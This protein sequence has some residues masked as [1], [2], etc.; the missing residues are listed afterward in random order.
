DR[1]DLRRDAGGRIELRCGNR[2][3]GRAR[4]RMAAD[5]GRR[6][7]PPRW[8]DRESRPALRPAGA[9]RG[10]RGGR[11][12]VER[13]APR[14]Q[15]ILPDARVPA[16]RAAAD[17]SGARR[18]TGSRLAGP[19]AGHPGRPA[20][21][22]DTARS[23]GA[24]RPRAVE[25]GGIRAGG[26][27]R[28]P[29]R[30]EG[31]LGGR[32]LFLEGDPPAGLGPWLWLAAAIPVICAEL[33]P[34]DRRRLKEI[35]GWSGPLHIAAGPDGSFERDGDTLPVWRVPV[36]SA[37]ERAKL[38][39]I[40]TG[41]AELGE[42]LGPAHRH[43]CARIAE[44]ARAGRYHAEISG[45]T[46]IGPDEIAAAARSGTGGDLGMFAELLPE[47]IPDEALVLPAAIRC[48]LESLTVRCLGRDALADGLGPASRARYRPGVR[49]LLVGPSGTGKN[50]AAAW[51]ATRL[52]LPIYRVDLASV[53]SK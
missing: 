52:G 26:A 34:G 32:P 46:R 45:G 4:A 39:Q 35:P 11:R 33:A 9:A 6:S 14:R 37:A 47:P 27:Q 22:A 30:G 24:P 53:T 31:G 15:R 5:A 41:N 7:P 21:F 13:T 42:R 38:W 51:L 44:L 25:A 40:T 2:P 28:S 49:A 19:P 18:S 20:A 43:A 10:A 48:E 12:A 1:V 3:H 29:A 50:L 23:G 16:D 36:P 8:T 17:R